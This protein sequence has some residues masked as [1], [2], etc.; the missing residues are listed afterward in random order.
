MTGFEFAK[1]FN[2]TEEKMIVLVMDAVKT[3]YNR[4]GLNFD[5]LSQAERLEIVGKYLGL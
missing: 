2:S 4:A 5:G 3:A 1:Q